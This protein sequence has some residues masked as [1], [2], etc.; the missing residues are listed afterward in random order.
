MKK[1]IPI[2]ILLPPK[3]KIGYQECH[4]E[5]RTNGDIVVTVYG[6]TTAC[7]TYVIKNAPQSFQT[8]WVKGE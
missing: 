1:M 5:T 6:D 7:E 2:Y 8:V 4:V 3:I